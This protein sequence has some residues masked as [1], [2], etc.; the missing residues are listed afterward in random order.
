MLRIAIVAAAYLDN[1][2]PGLHNQNELPRGWRL[3]MGGDILMNDGAGSPLPQNLHFPTAQTATMDQ[4]ASSVNQKA[5]PRAGLSA[6][7]DPTFEPILRGA[8]RPG[9]PSAWWSHVPFAHWIVR[10]ATPKVLVELGTHHGVSYSALCEAVLTEGLSTRCHAVDTWLGD[11][12][13]GEYGEEVYE[14]FRHFHDQRYATFSTLLRSTF[15]DAL[16]WFANGTIDLLHI[17]GLHTYE[18]VRHDFERWLPKLSERGIVLFHDTNVRRDD[19][20]VWQLWEELSRQYPCF[21]FLHGYGLGILAV[22]DDVPEDVLD[23]CRLS[24]P[25]EIAALRRR[26]ALIGE[27]CERAD[28]VGNAVAAAQTE[29]AALRVA[30]AEREGV[31]ARAEEMAAERETA[32]A[33]ANRRNAE[34]TAKLARAEEMAAEHAARSA[35]A[36]TALAEA[37]RRCEELKS[38]LAAAEG[39]SAGLREE[40]DRALQTAAEFEDIADAAQSAIDTLRARLA[41]SEDEGAERVALAESE[42]EALFEERDQIAQERDEIREERDRLAKEGDEWFEAAILAAM[43]RITGGRPLPGWRIG[44]YRLQIGPVRGKGSAM[45][46]ADRARAAQQWECAAHFYLEALEQRSPNRPAI[47]VQLGHALKEAGKTAEAEFAYRRAAR[48]DRRNTGALVPLGQLLRQ[49][50]R[51]AEAAAVYRYALDLVPSDELRAFLRG[52]LA[53]LGQPAE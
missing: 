43:E 2:G 46:R 23:L 25:E 48:L 27:R 3:I 50:G 12:H 41:R 35:S 53:A 45:Q 17:D 40:C 6:M 19:F 13:A 24:E 32:L 14:D 49:E 28:S 31:L 52:E 44:R 15:D 33:D 34:L 51:E 11:R 36:E 5:A 26:F 21:E 22:G 18:A 37:M 1:H 42:R 30:L 4:I 10:A 16:R 38:A 7:L 29:T 20:G 47:W 9:A 39:E 8:A